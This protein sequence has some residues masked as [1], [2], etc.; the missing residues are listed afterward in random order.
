MR[1]RLRL[2]DLNVLFVCLD[3]NHGTIVHRVMVDVTTFR[4]MGGNPLLVCRKGSVLDRLAELQSIRRFHLDQRG[5]LR[6]AYGLF[7]LVRS[8]V[9]EKALDLV[10]CYSYNPL[11]VL[12]LALK[13]ESR[14]PLLY[15]NNEEL[16]ERYYPF[17]HDYFV[18]RIDQVICFSPAQEDHVQ[19]ILPLGVRKVGFIGAGLEPPRKFQS[20]DHKGAWRLCSYV[21]PDESSIDQYIPLFAALPFL[22]LSG[23]KAVLSLITRG[24]WYEHPHYGLFK[25]AV[26]ERGLEHQVSFN[27]KPW[28]SDALVDQHLFVS[29][30][31]HAP[32][33]EHELE[34]LLHHVPA[35]LPRTS[36]RT[37]LLRGGSLGLTYQIGDVR[38]LRVKTLEMLQNYQAFHERVKHGAAELMEKHHFENYIDDLFQ[39]YERLA[40]QRL[41]FALKRRRPFASKS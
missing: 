14:I 8:L 27:P 31:S 1:E 39:L 28:G 12:G 33:E 7:K 34:A 4:N 22:E 20:V 29:L 15:T 11:L 6:A 18:T 10:H 37:H 30:S 25:R 32:F 17:W 41:R 3:V 9:K 19:E 36:V 2:S 13:H 35:L 23:E 16:S 21:S 24:S 26:L 5:G 38:E 40:L